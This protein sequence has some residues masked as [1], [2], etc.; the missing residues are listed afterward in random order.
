MN[1]PA[2]IVD[3]EGLLR[4]LDQSPHILFFIT[5]DFFKPAVYVNK[6]CEIF[7]GYTKKE[8]LRDVTPYD[9]IHPSERD[10]AKR[11][12]SDRERLKRGIPDYTFKVIRKDG[13]I[14]WVKC[15]FGKI[16]LTNGRNGLAAI[17]IPADEDVKAREFL[18]SVVDLM[19]EGV[20]IMDRNLRV[21]LFNEAIKRLAA[22]GKDPEEILGNFCY[23]I[24]YNRDTP[25]EDCA[26]VK[27]LKTSS[28]AKKNLHLKTRRGERW[29]EIKAKP[30]FDDTNYPFAAVE[31]IREITDQKLRERELVR[32]ERIRTL[33]QIAGGIAHDFN[34]ILAVIMASASTL[35][36]QMPDGSPLKQQVEAI[37]RACL[38]AK[39]IIHQ[40]LSFTDE[41]TGTPRRIDPAPLVEELV[42]IIS[43]GLSFPIEFEAEE[44]LWNIEI[45]PAQLNRAL[46]NIILNAIDAVREKGEGK[47]KVKLSNHYGP[48]P[49][50]DSP[51]RWVKIEVSDTG[52]GMD[53]AIVSHIFE[54]F[55]TTKPEGNGMGLAVAYSM[56]KRCGGHIDVK[57]R[58]GEGSTFTVYI[59]AAS[60]PAKRGEK[61]TVL[62]LE[63]QQALREVV[64]IYL[65]GKGFY[66]LEAET[67]EQAVKMA[68]KEK[69]DAFILDLNIE[70]GLGAFEIAEQLKRLNPD[71]TYILTTGY[72]T[73]SARK[74]AEDLGFSRILQ[75]PYKLSE[76]VEILEG[77]DEQK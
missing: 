34:N 66:V 2:N 13:S 53:P 39:D 69:V 33:E 61:R 55:F 56:V 29:F 63:D 37:E 47:V 15:T 17:G 27:A 12:F 24:V 58:P 43:K 20:A 31:Y 54:P 72:L 3:A 10:R 28:M 26:V 76:L 52:I 14:R 64:R 50:G 32:E 45:D 71:A 16:P 38:K 23:K 7:S 11:T 51:Q 41:S 9:L 8:L 48:L 19:D 77:G 6:A 40:F 74:M 1:I 65:E 30:I 67:G 36:L 68:D 46:Q 18:R 75:K 25:C 35:K 42:K 21:L 49:H 59:P 4:F 57:S 44:N 70:K 60:G 73:E 5:V 22:S 62:V